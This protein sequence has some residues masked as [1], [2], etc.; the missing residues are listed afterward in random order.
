MNA[1]SIRQ[2]ARR[3]FWVAS[4]V[5]GWLM[6]SRV[7]AQTNFFSEGSAAYRAANYT[8][9][10][11]AFERAA[12]RQPASGTLQNLGLAEWQRGQ[13]AAAILAWEQAVWMDPFNAATR[14]N[15]RFARKAAMVQAPEYSWCEAASM[16]LPVNV[17]PLLAAGSFWLA[18]AMVLLSRV[19]RWRR[20]TWH[21]VLAAAGFA[22]FL[23]CL[24]SLYGVHTRARIGFVMAKETPLRLT[25]TRDAQAIQ[26]LQEGQPVRCERTRG[27]YWFV[28][29]GSGHGWIECAQ[30]GRIC[31]E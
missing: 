13:R 25:P 19:F 27:K 14:E 31:P 17:W 20:A 3:W 9:A 6:L 26:V 1:S 7:Q 22:V 29:T 30:V 2:G 16:W 4:L 24:P 10:A 28:R 5:L 23:V 15:L 21:Q 12:T 8:T 18:V 11:N